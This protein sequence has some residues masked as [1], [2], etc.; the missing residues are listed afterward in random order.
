MTSIFLL[1]HGGYWQGDDNDSPTGKFTR[2]PTGMTV[3][4]YALPDQGLLPM[5]AVE[6]LV[7]KAAAGDLG[8]KAAKELIP[9][10]CFSPLEELPWMQVLGR[11]SLP[12]EARFIGKGDLGNSDRL[13]LTSGSCTPDSHKCG[14]L[15]QKFTGVTH[16][17]LLSCRVGPLSVGHTDIGAAAASGEF[18]NTEHIPGETPDNP[19]HYRRIVKLAEDILDLVGWDDSKECFTDPENAEAG[20]QFDTLDRVDQ[21]KVLAAH[22]VW[23]WSR[24]REARR[25]F[26][27]HQADADLLAF[28]EWL[29]SRAGYEID[30]YRRDGV[31]ASVVAQ[32]GI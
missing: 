19:A 20:K 21:A 6:I 1:G 7:T 3:H 22:E 12:P 30:F 28:V 18:A 15:F 4:F 14:G 32:A 11:I 27:Q 8:S 29:K 2:V 9:N 25:L 10:Y 23:V 17:H 16:L 13:C 24:V 31:L 26:K 5:N